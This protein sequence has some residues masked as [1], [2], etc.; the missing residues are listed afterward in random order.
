MPENL[1]QCDFLVIGGG[2]AG[3]SA[4]IEASYH[5]KVILL[6][7][8]KTGETATEYAQGG[9]A[10]A[11]DE[12]KDSPLYH[13]K[14]T[15]A[16]GAGLCDKH[17]VEVLVNDGVKRV[18]ELIR[19]GARFDKQGK[20][21]ELAME[22]AHQHRRILHAGDAT[23]AEIEKT[24]AAKLLKEKLV[25]VKNF[26]FG[27]DLVLKDGKCVGATAFDTKNESE[28][29]FL[30]KATLLAT[31]GLGQVFLYNTNPSFATG[32]GIAMAYR[33][34]AQVTDMEFVQF[35]PTALVIKNIQERFLIS[36]AVRGE[37]AVLLNSKGKRFV[38]EL[39]PRD[40][41][42]RAIFNEMKK[43]KSDHI[44]LDF[45]PIGKSKIKE[46]F[47]T[48]YLECS[49]YGIDVSQ[50]PAP[51]SP[52][53]HYFMGGIKIDVNGRSS[54]A[55]LY[56]AGEASSAGIHGAN[57]LASNSLLDGLV[58]GYRSA[59]DAAKHFK[60]NLSA[61]ADQRLRPRPRL[62]SEELVK[63]KDSIKRTMW[64]KVGIIRS[65]G[66]LS[67]ALEELSTI[68]KKLGRE[69]GSA[70]EQEVLN[71]LSVANLIS[72]AALDRTESRGAH[73]RQ[74]YPEQDDKNW[75]KHLVYSIK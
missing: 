44:D 19:T 10:A 39:A 49:K 62:R 26:V 75:K 40:I 54:I 34:G 35:H 73:Y 32:D 13:L 6:T 28:L 38:N 60:D 21:F 31:G 74:D 67:K 52:A 43:E 12:E 29:V 27:K 65:K 63:L 3:L 50:Q 24:L 7:K 51:I 5:G 55:G 11:I 16:A 15:L 37:G 46:R 61:P 58:F 41:V 20:D 2:I 56:A 68:E 71:M 70:D 36:E 66:S 57:R 33:A 22:G 64:N 69:A 4:A 48:I 18:K 47:P 1:Y 8:G 14:D 9:I 72:R 17:A 59:V 23:G 30:A 53:A 42:A 25:E 45:S